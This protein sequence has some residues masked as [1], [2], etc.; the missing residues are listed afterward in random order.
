MH[1]RLTEAS[2]RA[3]RLTIAAVA[4]GVVVRIFA[5]AFKLSD[6]IPFADA[7]FYSTQALGVRQ[8]DGFNHLFSK[9]P[10]AEH[11]PLTQILLAPASFGEAAGR[12]GDHQRILMTFFG[13][14]SLVL[15]ALVAR[16]LLPGLYASLAV[17]IAA[18]YP[19]I[20]LHDAIVMSETIAL[21]LINATMLLL[22]DFRRH[23]A[24]WRAVALGIATGLATLARSELVLFAVLVGMAAW[25]FQRQRP[26]SS[27]NGVRPILALVLVGAGALVTVAPW[28]V[29]NRT[30]FDEP[31]YLTTNDGTTFLG[32][33]CPDTFYGRGTGSWSVFCVFGHESPPGGDASTTAR[34]RRD[35]AFEY[36]GDHLDRLPVVLVARVGRLLNVFDP[37]GMV[38]GD[39][40]EDKFDWALWV[41]VVMWWVMMPLAV[42]GLVR[43]PRRDLFVL[44]GPIVVVVVSTLVFYGSPRLRVPLEPS[45]V[46]AVCYGVYALRR[47]F[48][49]AVG[50]EPTNHYGRSVSGA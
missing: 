10:T 22:L 50:G 30:R 5:L 7:L 1:G 44:G 26:V 20:W 49:G 32:A 46:L 37:A 8:G 47:R 28:L 17:L 15:F 31:V 48:G 35:L 36:A 6:P 14:L 34:L 21:L 41:G 23:P 42:V 39:A 2:R 11:G 19:N 4:V 12:V 40:M 3:D 38:A 16:R 24:W 29:E 33:Y 13:I 27:R 18:V 25:W 9:E 43:M 45:I